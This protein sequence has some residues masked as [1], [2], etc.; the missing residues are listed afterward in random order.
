MNNAGG[1][2]IQEIKAGNEKTKAQMLT[3]YKI[4]K[5]RGLNDTPGALHVNNRGD[6]RF[7]PGASF[8]PPEKLKSC[9]KMT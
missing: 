6:P 5:T 9:M 2:M 8:T 3:Q 4:S 1:I 7:P